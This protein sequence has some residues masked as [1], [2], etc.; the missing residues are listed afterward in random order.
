MGAYKINMATIFS[1]TIKEMGYEIFFKDD[2]TIVLKK[3]NELFIS[4]IMFETNKKELLGAVRVK[5]LIYSRKEINN[6][7]DLLEAD[8]KTFKQLSNYDIMN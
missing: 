7:F 4:L 5:Q 2:K 6:A 8:L 3:E 1:K